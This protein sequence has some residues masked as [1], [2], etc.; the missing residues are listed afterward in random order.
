MPLLAADREAWEERREACRTKNL[1]FEFGI[2]TCFYVQ[3]ARREQGR[4]AGHGGGGGVHRSC[5]GLSLRLPCVHR[6]WFFMY[7]LLLC[8]KLSGSFDG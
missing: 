3:Y 7:L 1:G 5:T 2:Y 6:A 4:R 8:Q